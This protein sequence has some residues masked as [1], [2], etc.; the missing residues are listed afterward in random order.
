VSRP[1]TNRDGDGTP[2]IAVAS[3]YRLDLAALAEPFG[4]LLHCHAPAGEDFSIA[5]LGQ[6]DDGRDRWGA[7]RLRTAYLAS[8]PGVALAEYARHCQ[9]D[10]GPERRC[11][12]A[13]RLEPVALLD[14]RRPEVLDALGLPSGARQFTERAVARRTAT[15]IRSTGATPGLIVPSMAFLDQPDRFNV[16]LFV[17][18]VRGGLETVVSGAQP[19]GEVRIERR[20]RIAP[21][22]S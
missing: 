20:D 18:L 17:E 21:T 2:A 15:A 5:G 8:D 13:V 6:I 11:L 19:I 9:P 1:K 7:P 10:G 14:L 3:S 4:G 16:V 12:H 22:R